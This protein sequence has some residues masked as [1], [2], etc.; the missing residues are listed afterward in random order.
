M[1]ENGR[2]FSAEER[3]EHFKGITDAWAKQVERDE[4]RIKKLEKEV[5]KKTKEYDEAE[6]DLDKA[7]LFLGKFE[8]LLTKFEEM[9]NKKSDSD[10]E[11]KGEV[12][13]SFRKCNR[14]LKK[15][16]DEIEIFK[17]QSLNLDQLV[18]VYTQYSLIYNE[19]HA[20]AVMSGMFLRAA[21]KKAEYVEEDDDDDDDD[22]E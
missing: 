22:D 16:N 17:E 10:A 12:L 6:A 2:S 19:E 5:E 4:K 21:R 18:R 9:K 15:R 8:N 7:E 11:S 3:K 13:E 20:R 1:S 14:I